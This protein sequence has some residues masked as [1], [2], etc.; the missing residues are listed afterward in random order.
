MVVEITIVIDVDEDNYNE[1]ELKQDIQ[2]GFPERTG[3]D[4]EEL[5]IKDND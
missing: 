5:Y 2:Q 4:I 3:Y 1:R